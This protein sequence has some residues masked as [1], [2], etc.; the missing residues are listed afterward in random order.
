M[1][2]G[3]NV[4]NK[5]DL[6][7]GRSDPSTLEETELGNLVTLTLKSFAIRTVNPNPTFTIAPSLSA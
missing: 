6:D 1:L 3:R 5:F 2:G 4:T 7:K